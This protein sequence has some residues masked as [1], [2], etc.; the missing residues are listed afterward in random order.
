MTGALVFFTLFFD[1]YH[2]IAQYISRKQA[3]EPKLS[4]S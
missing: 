3:L 4:E 2:N 1:R